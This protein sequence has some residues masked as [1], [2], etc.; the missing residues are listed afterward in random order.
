[1]IVIL[2]AGKV[3]YYFYLFGSPSHL[4]LA[5]MHPINPYSGIE[6]QGFQFVS[7][8]FLCSCPCFDFFFTRYCLVNVFEMFTVDQVKNIVSP[9]EVMWI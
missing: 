8:F 2:S 9:R 4:P 7:T 6:T 5:A 1:M 3:S